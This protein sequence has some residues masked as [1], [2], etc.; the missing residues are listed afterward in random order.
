M[1][2]VSYMGYDGPGVVHAHYFANRLTGAR[3]RSLHAAQMVISRAAALLG[4]YTQL[5]N[6]VRG[7]EEQTR[8]SRCYG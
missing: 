7:L 1:R 8:A 5:T 4:R 6:Q 2:I 3:Q